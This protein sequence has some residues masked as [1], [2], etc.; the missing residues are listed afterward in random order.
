PR[1]GF[2]AGARVACRRTRCGRA[3]TQCRPPAPPRGGGRRG[4]SHAGSSV[5]PGPG[6]SPENAWRA[7]RGDRSAARTRSCH[8][9]CVVLE[10]HQL[11]LLAEEPLAVLRDQPPQ[12]GGV[13]ARK[14][15]DMRGMAPLPAGEQPVLGQVLDEIPARGDVPLRQRAQ[16]IGADEALG[17]LQASKAPGAV[18]LRVAALVVAWAIPALF[19][20]PVGAALRHALGHELVRR[21]AR[22]EWKA[23]GA[24]LH[25][26]RSWA[27]CASRAGVWLLAFAV[28]A[29]SKLVAKPAWTA[30]VAIV[31]AHRDLV[32]G[33]P[34]RVVVVC[35]G[36][37][38][39]FRRLVRRRGVAP[40]RALAVV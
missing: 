7:G 31:P 8:T 4:L 5:A 36:E 32:R 26:R 37:A 38:L 40:Q 25:R 6:R 34:A 12:H 35:A 1:P 10:R 28:A 17:R 29:V 2:C 15:V 24:W 11:R 9:S 14:V 39:G 16:D 21:R 30:G 13:V 19:E 18:M 23:D 33:T 3:A 27:G 22:R 20:D